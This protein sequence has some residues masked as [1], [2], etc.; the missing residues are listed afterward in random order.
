LFILVLLLCGRGE[1]SIQLTYTIEVNAECSAAWVIEQKGIGVPPPVFDEFVR[2]VSLLI[3][4][5]AEKTQRNMTAESLSMSVNVSGSYKIIRYYFTW[6]NF[7]QS[8]NG[9]IVMGDVFEVENFFSYLYGDGA[10]RISYPLDSV[11]ESVSPEPHERDDRF[12]VLEWYG[13]AD[14]K[15]GEPKVTFAKNPDIWIAIK[16]I[17]FVVSLAVLAGGCFI[18]T[19]YLKFKRGKE[20]MKEKIYVQKMGNDEEKVISLLRSAGGS[21]YQSAIADH[22][23]FSRAKASKLLKS[24]E[25]RGIVK[26]EDKGRE[27]IVTLLE[28]VKSEKA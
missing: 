20:K 25:D 16:N 26:R 14:F 5:A 13:T 15:T 12:H 7:A 3:S 9:K 27:K 19:Y 6:K 22:C 18:G 4:L 10:V 21:L 8:V 23:G 24:M 1:A 11:V 28:E 2:K 17:I